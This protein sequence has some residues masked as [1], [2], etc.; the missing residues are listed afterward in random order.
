MASIVDD[1]LS[2]ALDDL[3][4]IDSLLRRVKAVAA[5]LDLNELVQWADR[6]LFGYQS[7]DETPPYR[8]V[9]GELHG[10]APGGSWVPVIWESQDE[11]KRLSTRPI[12]DSIGEI[13]DRVQRRN[14]Q[15][16]TLPLG[17]MRLNGPLGK[18]LTNIALLTDR[19]VFVNMVSVVRSR[20]SDWAVKLKKAGIKGEGL[21]FSEPEKQKAHTDQASIHIGNIEQFTGNIGSQSIE[22]SSIVS[23]QVSASLELDLKG[24]KALAEQIGEHLSAL[25]EESIP[26]VREGLAVINDELGK[27]TPSQSKIRSALGSIRNVLE[28]AAGNLI[29]SGIAFELAKILPR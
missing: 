12:R 20:I 3:V 29:A 17:S 11:R 9:T 6:E 24:V 14:Q 28:G 19:A 8:M 2:Q 10:W 1:L 27:R 13:W 18:Q 16:W 26:S 23:T 15:R 7:T 22:Q 4:P 5:L 21:S 25:P